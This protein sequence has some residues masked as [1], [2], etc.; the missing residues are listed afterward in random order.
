MLLFSKAIVNL[1]KNLSGK[2]WSASIFIKNSTSFLWVQEQWGVAFSYTLHWWQ[3]I[4]ESKSFHIV[5]I[6]NPDAFLCSP[7]KWSS[8]YHSDAEAA[9]TELIFWTLQ[10]ADQTRPQ[11]Q[12]H[13][14]IIRAARSRK[15]RP[16]PEK[17]KSPCKCQ[18]WTRAMRTKRR[19]VNTGMKSATTQAATGV[20]EAQMSHFKKGTAKHHVNSNPCTDTVL[21]FIYL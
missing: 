3:N 6:N 2:L 1:S 17:V 21:H 13:L 10:Q 9:I 8:P 7:S 11:H 15:N 14:P 18:W 20:S 4:K 5:Y 16:E 19:G 12:L